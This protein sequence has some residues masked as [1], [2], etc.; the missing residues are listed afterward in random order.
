MSTTKFL[1]PF[2]LLS[3][4]IVLPPRLA[5]AEPTQTD[6]THTTAAA[7]STTSRLAALREGVRE[8]D[9]RAKAIRARMEHA[10]QQLRRHSR[11]ILVTVEQDQMSIATRLEILQ[12]AAS[13]V[14]EETVRS[15]EATYGD[16]IK[17]LARV[18]SWYQPPRRPS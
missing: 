5:S 3:A 17:L 18:E 13:T 12:T 15:M 8:L 4:T 14:D 16:A 7:S 11:R 10:T 9:S 1:V 6:A 2:V